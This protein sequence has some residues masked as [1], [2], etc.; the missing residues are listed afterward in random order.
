VGKGGLAP[1]LLRSIPNDEE[2]GKP[3]FLT[4]KLFSVCDSGGTRPT[5]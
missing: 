4:L 3:P 1:A 2:R 5:H